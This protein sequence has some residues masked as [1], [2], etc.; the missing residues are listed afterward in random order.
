[1]LNLSRAPQEPSASWTLLHRGAN[2]CRGLMTAPE[3]VCTSVDGW[4]GSFC[5]FSR[6]GEPCSR[7][8]SEGLFERHCDE[9]ENG[10]AHCV[11]CEG[12]RLCYRCGYTDPFTPR[13]EEGLP[14]CAGRYVLLHHFFGRRSIHIAG[15]V[16]TLLAFNFLL[17]LFG[18]TAFSR[19]EQRRDE[20]ARVDRQ[21]SNCSLKFS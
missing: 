14:T 1:M 13:E 17:S 15:V 8:R 2:R 5:F 9:S 19:T 18:E 7:K 6:M 16:V 21:L 12:K 10:C 4:N 11:R 3:I 20:G